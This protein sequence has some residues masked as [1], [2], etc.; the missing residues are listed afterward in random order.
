MQERSL[1]IPSSMLNTAYSTSLESLGII[2]TLVPFRFV[3]HLGHVLELSLNIDTWRIII[4]YRR[5][6]ELTD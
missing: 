4:S 5:L 3:I 2:T 6:Y 1:A